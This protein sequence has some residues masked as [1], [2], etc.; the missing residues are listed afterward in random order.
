MQA[1]LHGVAPRASK[2][3]HLVYRKLSQSPWRSNNT[4]GPVGPASLSR[5]DLAH[6]QLLMII[7]L[8]RS[9]HLLWCI[10]ALIRGPFHPELRHRRGL[11][12]CTCRHGRKCNWHFPHGLDG[13]NLIVFVSFPFICA[14]VLEERVKM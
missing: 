7:V 14:L 10:L 13:L 5:S 9:V 11:Q 4:F 12:G 3:S 2:K 6:L 8:P 1:M